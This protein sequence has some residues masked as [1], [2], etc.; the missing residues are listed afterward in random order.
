[1]H[2]LRLRLCAVFLSLTTVL[3]AGLVTSN[4]SSRRPADCVEATAWSCEALSAGLA[5]FGRRAFSPRIEWTILHAIRRL[6]RRFPSIQWVRVAGLEGFRV[7]VWVAMSENPEAVSTSTRGASSLPPSEFNEAVAIIDRWID[8]RDAVA[9]SVLPRW[10]DRFTTKKNKSQD[11]LMEGH[12]YEL[13]ALMDE[14]FQRHTEDLGRAGRLFSSLAEQFNRDGYK[15]RSEDFEH[16]SAEEQLICLY[17]AGYH[18]K[19]QRRFWD[20]EKERQVQVILALYLTRKIQA[21]SLRICDAGAAEAEDRFHEVSRLLAKLNSGSKGKAPVFVKNP[22]YL[23]LVTASIVTPTVRPYW[24]MY[25]N[26]RHMFSATSQVEFHKANIRLLTAHI[27]ANAYNPSYV[28]K[29]A[30][31]RADFDNGRSGNFI[32][33]TLILLDLAALL[34]AWSAET[35]LAERHELEEV[36]FQGVSSDPWFW[37][38]RPEAIW[39]TVM[40]ENLFVTRREGR[41]ELSADG[42]YLRERVNVF[43]RERKVWAAAQ[44]SGS[45]PRRLA[46]AFSPYGVTYLFSEWFIGGLAKRSLFSNEFDGLSLDDALVESAD[47]KI[48]AW[49]NTFASEYAWATESPESQRERVRY[50]PAF[51]VFMLETTASCIDQLAREN[52]QDPP[53]SGLLFMVIDASGKNRWIP[54]RDAFLNHPLAVWLARYSTNV[55]HLRFSADASGRRQALHEYGVVPSHELEASRNQ[56][57]LFEAEKIGDTWFGTA[58]FETLELLAQGKIPVIAGLSD[59]SAQVIRLALPHAHAIPV[60]PTLTPDQIAVHVSEAIAHHLELRRQA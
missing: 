42:L 8:Q 17:L 34:E 46:A 14:G 56:G 21:L 59:V 39:P 13:L 9:Q 55:A 4:V 5:M 20:H 29:R 50:A 57:A 51:K 40:L 30:P 7:P 3:N 45:L 10:P 49:A 12:A 18:Q 23:P 11:A 60:S 33:Y 48:L 43:L 27:Q 32:D 28:Q 36:I 24:Q 25:E 54:L 35:D 31:L 44:R 47:P 26:I 41:V 15:A 37:L 58:K 16:Q 19:S 53:W 6:P 2:S 22:Y 38:G 1:M 52:G